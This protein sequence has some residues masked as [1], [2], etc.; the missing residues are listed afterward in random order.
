MK[1]EGLHHAIL[2][3]LSME[4]LDLS[5]LRSILPNFLDIKEH[6]LVGLLAQRQLLIRI[7]QY[8]DF[9]DALSRVW[10]SFPNL[11]MDLFAKRSL[12]SIASA[13][14]KPIS[15]DKARQVR[16]RPSTTRVR[17]ILD[18]MDKHPDCIQLQNKN[19]DQSN[20]GN[21]KCQ[22][23]LPEVINMLMQQHVA[24]LV[25][26]IPILKLLMGTLEAS[27]CEMPSPSMELIGEQRDDFGHKLLFKENEQEVDGVVVLI[28]IHSNNK[29]E[30][31]SD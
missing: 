11:S 15:M 20:F 16:S 25:Y 24:S 13:V 23:V 22:I 2:V 26:P 9:V 6:F 12:F 14:G 7:D 27:A 29:V 17:V 3:K 1:Q 19:K 4:S 8:N 21:P 5:I 30:V 31:K 28:P 10:N 18:V